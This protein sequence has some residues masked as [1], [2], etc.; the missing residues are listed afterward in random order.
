MGLGPIGSVKVSI[1]MYNGDPDAA[2]HAAAAAAARCV[3]SLTAYQPLPNINL[4]SDKL[5][6]SENPTQNLIFFTNFKMVMVLKL[7]LLKKLI[8]LE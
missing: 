1:T 3:H 6:L 8:L 4:A 7:V 2:D 5:S